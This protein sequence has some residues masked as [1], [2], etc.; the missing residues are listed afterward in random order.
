MIKLITIYGLLFSLSNMLM[1][2]YPVYKGDSIDIV[3]PYIW[4]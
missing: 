1:L 3:N 2:L 4:P